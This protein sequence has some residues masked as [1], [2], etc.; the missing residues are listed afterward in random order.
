MIYIQID[1]D[2]KVLFTHNMPFDEQYGLNK[3]EQELLLDGYLIDSVPEIPVVDKKIGSY[4]YNA[5]TNSLDIVYSDRP[6]RQEEKI[7]TLEEQNA[8]M[9]LALVMGGLL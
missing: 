2:N 1:Q 4:V 3:T 7:E 8:Q 5:D 6:Q 9:L